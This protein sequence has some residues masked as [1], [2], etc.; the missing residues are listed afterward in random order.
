MA[1]MILSTVGAAVGGLFGGAGAA[2]G[3]AAG[4][5][6]GNAID[7]AVLGDNAA[8]EGPRLEEVAFTSV[9]E[10]TAIPRAYGTVR[11][12]GHLIWATRFEE[13]AYTE[14]QGGKAPPSGPDVTTYSYFGNAAYALC[15]GPIS[16]VRRVWADGVEIDRT[17]VE[18]RVYHGTEDQLPDPLIEARQGGPAPAFR[19]TAYVVF[20]RLPLERYGNRLPQFSFE[21]IRAVNTLAPRVRAITVIP[22]STEHGYDPD[23]V[24][25][26]VLPGASE[27]R[28]RHV[29]HATSDWAASIDELTAICPNLEA[30]SLVVAW[31]GDDLDAARCRIEPRVES[32]APSIGAAND[33]SVGASSR[34]RATLVSRTDGRP[35]YGGTPSDHS[36]IEAIGDLRARGLKVY[37]YPFV[38]LDIP[39]GNGLSDPYGRAEQPPHPWRGRITAS[40]AP[41]RP[42]SADGTAAADAAV[43]RFV[44]TDAAPNYAAMIDHYARLC[45]GA[46]GVDGFVI[47]SEMR[48]LTQLRG[49]KGYPFVDAL[50]AIAARARAVLGSDTRI[51]YAADWSEYF[52]HQPADGSGDVFYHLDPLWA[53]PAISAVGIDNYMPLADWREGDSGGASPDGM[54]SPYDRTALAAS[55]TA[56]EGY[57]WFY[58]D[59]QFRRTRRRIPIKDPAYGKPWVFRPKDVAR[60]WGNYHY[61]RRKGREGL[62]PTAWRPGMKPIV[63]TE[64]GAPAVDKAANGPNVFPD[65]KS[66]ENAL[67]PHSTGA[68]DDLAQH[69]FLSAH[70][71][72][73]DAQGASAP[74]RASDVFLWT[75]DARPIPAFPVQTD[76]W[77]DGPNWSVGHWLNG[78]LSGASLGD[79]ITAVL[80]DH[81]IEGSDTSG[82]EGWATGLLLSDPSSARRAVEPI[83]EM[84][85]IGAVE[86]DGELVFRTLARSPAPRALPA[87]AAMPD[88]PEIVRRRGSAEEAPSEAVIA[89]RDPMRDHAVAAMRARVPGAGAGPRVAVGTRLTLEREDAARLAHGFLRRA[90]EER[91][92]VEADLPWSAVTIRVGDHVAHPLLGA[93]AARVEAI[94]DGLTRRVTLRVPN[95]AIEVPPAPADE[96]RAPAPTIRVGPPRAAALDLPLVPGRGTGALVA[97]WTRPWAPLA[98]LSETAGGLQARGTILEPCG[99]GTL[100]AALTPGPVA[101]P[102]RGSKAVLALPGRALESISTRALLDGANALAVR[103][104]DAW[105]VLQFRDADEIAPGLWELSFL[106]R[107]RLGTEH[108][109]LSGAARGADAVLLDDAPFWIADADP[110]RAPDAWRVGRRGAPVDAERYVSVTGASGLEALR[111][112]APVHLRAD[113]GDDGALRC[114][115]VRR[116]RVDADGWLAEDIPLGE[117]REAYAVRLVGPNGALERRTEEARITIRAADLT[118]AGLSGGTGTLSVRQIGSR[119]AAGHPATAP[120]RL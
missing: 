83:L 25:R 72:R 39:P 70:L 111:P 81:G 31:F 73:I 110:E 66:S 38:L 102:D 67:P 112:L 103:C 12:A 88:E 44:G 7:R 75:W 56:G 30:V 97:G 65:P 43:R 107:A 42:N 86:R 55:V 101:V 47:G 71:D 5:L 32:R 60:W 52:G 37:L 84:H 109:M 22:G 96:A 48:A 106:L 79:L 95:D 28:N 59:D 54:R 51:T 89:H 116:G 98:V 114:S 61:E 90:R 11:T 77:S 18:M 10:G 68:R 113:R 82:V 117:E 74:V 13:S 2:L 29:L 21:V 6:L 87:I 64:L 27:A 4:G 80:H 20:E 17:E 108:A 36:V 49:A 23:P 76:V 100:H 14:R 85:G 118:A 9:G 58:P 53:D 35:N 15:E 94:E 120:I 62:L 78:R 63:F 24:R 16:H 8:I 91:E 119:V 50:R 26:D 46:G 69:A 105:E 45:H 41:G 34:L 93:R 3:R 104:A 33:W 40:P 1:T 115:W 92:S 57:D 99:M 19:G